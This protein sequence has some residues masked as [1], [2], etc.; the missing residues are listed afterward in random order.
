MS[1]PKERGL[2]RL[3]P[4]LTPSD[5]ASTCRSPSEFEAQ[6][7]SIIHSEES[8][9]KLH[10]EAR[11]RQITTDA[12]LKEL[13]RA[14][15]VR[16]RSQDSYTFNND[17]KEEKRPSWSHGRRANKSLYV[18]ILNISLD[19]TKRNNNILQNERPSVQMHGLHI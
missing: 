16:K 4:F 19:C 13:L 1:Q 3:L 7:H 5:T 8:F 9:D 14:W 18:E 15:C 6:S 12:G 2:S 10:Q 11:Q 17:G